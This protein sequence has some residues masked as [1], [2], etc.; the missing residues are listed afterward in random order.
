MMQRI[1]FLE[2]GLLNQLKYITQLEIQ[3]S[4][5]DSQL[6]KCR[7]CQQSKI[8]PTALGEQII[9]TSVHPRILWNLEKS[10]QKLTTQACQIVQKKLTDVQK[11]ITGNYKNKNLNKEQR[12]YLFKV[13]ALEKSYFLKLCSK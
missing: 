2:E 12:D 3:S 10:P 9:A 7:K 13:V 6:K 4:Q 1:V 5:I 11:I 8:T